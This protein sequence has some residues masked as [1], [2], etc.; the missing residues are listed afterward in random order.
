MLKFYLFPL[1]VILVAAVVLVLT[2]KNKR[3]WTLTQSFWFFV[4]STVGAGAS[5]SQVIWFTIAW[6]GYAPGT[7]LFFIWMFSIISICLCFGML[8]FVENKTNDL[9]E[10]LEGDFN[11]KMFDK[12]EYVDCAIGYLVFKNG[13][14]IEVAADSRH[15][16]I[17][18]SGVKATVKKIPYPKFMD[19]LQLNSRSIWVSLSRNAVS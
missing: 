13:W 7:H 12:V 15:D 19:F 9:K 11:L 10:G 3:V 8:L 2:L 1:V 5:L 17:L 4:F 14:K 16:W 6:S 18:E